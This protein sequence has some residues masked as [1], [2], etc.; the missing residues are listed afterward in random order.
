[1]LLVAAGLCVRTLRNAA[2][3]DTGYE[4][5]SVLTARIDL[6]KQK[7]TEARGTLLQQ[8]LL[9]R[10]QSLPGVDAAGFGVTLPLNDG[11]WEDAG[12]A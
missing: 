2:A 3:I 7:Y 10:V 1:M 9:E 12:P 5:R 6:G 8:Q 4:A 11:R